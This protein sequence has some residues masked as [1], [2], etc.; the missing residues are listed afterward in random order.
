ME[1]SP[2][3]PL[4]QLLE[5]RDTEQYLKMRYPDIELP[6]VGTATHL[7]KHVIAELLIK[8]EVMINASKRELILSTLATPKLTREE[9]ESCES[10]ILN[11]LSGA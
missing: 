3:N 2:E 1:S 6:A 9:F 5:F 8:Y 4:E 11:S 7:Y 10:L